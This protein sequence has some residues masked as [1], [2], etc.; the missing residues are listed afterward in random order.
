MPTQSEISLSPISAKG[1]LL[2]TDGSSRTRVQVG[3]NG[4][5][6]TARSSATSGVQF[7]T[8]GGGN[9]ASFVLI[10]SATATTDVTTLTISFTYDSSYISYYVEGHWR[11]TRNTDS[12]SAIWVNS[13]TYST[14]SMMA[15]YNYGQSATDWSTSRYLS[16]GPGTIH[17]LYP[18]YANT[19]YFD[20]NS[21][22]PYKF[23]YFGKFGNPDAVGPWGSGTAMY[24]QAL[25]SHGSLYDGTTTGTLYGRPQITLTGFPNTSNFTSIMLADGNPSF[26]SIASG[27]TVRLYGIKRP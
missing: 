1:D 6:L 23:Y 11:C 25:G 20:S 3:T 24:Y 2:S 18:A 10:G 16:N 27:T 8:A 14:T 21:F 26:S 22:A 4:Q 13:T 15:L 5:I 12:E 9:T 19:T 7:E 17:Q